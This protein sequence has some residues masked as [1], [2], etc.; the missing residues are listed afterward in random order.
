MPCGS[1]GDYLMFLVRRADYTAIDNKRVSEYFL[2]GG[3]GE[4]GLAFGF[5]YH[6][7]MSAQVKTHPFQGFHRVQC[8]LLGA[9]GSEPLA[10]RF[11][12]YARGIEKICIMFGKVPEF[13]DEVQTIVR[14]AAMKQTDRAGVP[15]IQRVAHNSIERRETTAGTNQQQWLIGRA[16]MIKT[17]AMRSFNREAI[18]WEHPLVQPR[19][20]FTVFQ[21]P[22]MYLNWFIILRQTC[23]R[24]TAYKIIVVAV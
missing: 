24:I 15:V 20:H 13:I 18:A 4:K 17:I 1:N 8:N 7:R 9:A 23:S 19:G 5:P 16:S 22:H 21:M 3:T 6:V 2:E 14:T 10:H 12:R 11:G